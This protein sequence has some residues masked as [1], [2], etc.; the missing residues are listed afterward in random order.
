MWAIPAVVAIS[1]ALPSLGAWC[2]WAPDSLTTY[3]SLARTLARTG[4]LP[5]QRLIAPPGYSVML[6]PLVLLWGDTPMLAIRVVQALMLLLIAT[7]TFFVHRRELSHGGALAAAICVASSPVLLGLSA[8]PLSEIFF[9][10]LICAWLLLIGR[11]E[12]GRFSGWWEGAW[13][14]VLCAA[15]MLTRSIGGV[16]VPISL[17]VLWRRARGPIRLGRLAAFSACVVGPSVTWELR[18]NSFPGVDSYRR[19]WT[20][21]TWSEPANLRGPPL[22]AHRLGSFGILRLA[23]LKEAFISPDPF[24][25][26]YASPFARLSSCVIGGAI[27]IVAFAKFV[28][29]RRAADALVIATVG[30]LCFWPYDEGVRLIAPLI[31]VLAAYPVWVI[32]R[33]LRS[34]RPFSQRAALL[35]SMAWMCSQAAGVIRFEATLPAHRDKELARFRQMRDLAAWQAATL[36]ARGDYIGITPY[37]DNSKLVLAGAS[38]LSERVVRAIDFMPNGAFDIPRDAFDAA[39]VHQSLEEQARQRWG[40]EPSAHTGPFALFISHLPDLPTAQ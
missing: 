40:T 24:W 26:L 31:P 1:L 32:Q 7:S 14:G 9:T 11:W 5:A 21:S 28:R 10:T 4:Q 25:R 27:L 36:P 20:Q 16:T 37:R 34:R 13:G 23:A 6:A 17:W 15:I 19:A 30:L 12:E 22:Y 39:F 38:Y 3:L 35:F 29:H 2:T 33:G 18:Q 8:T